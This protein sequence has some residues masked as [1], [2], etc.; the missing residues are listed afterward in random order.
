LAQEIPN[1]PELIERA[2]IFKLKPDAF[3][4][5]K[6]PVDL[7]FSTRNDLGIIIRYY[8]S[9]YSGL[10]ISN[11]TD[12]QHLKKYL[13]KTYYMPLLES[14]LRQR[15]GI[16]NSRLVIPVNYLY[17]ILTNIEYIYQ[18]KNNENRLY[19]KPL[20]RL[21]SPSLKFYLAAPLVLFALDRTGKVK[22]DYI[23]LFF[24]ELKFC[25]PIDINEDENIWEN[26]RNL[27]L[28]AYR[29]YNGF[30]LIK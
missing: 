30:H 22:D 11:W 13:I 12:L 15:S 5:E 26:A 20:A 7:W 3:I 8:L 19:F 4:V 17:H 18:L 27:Y 21:I 29:L 23:N 10:A 24:N 16:F 2:T 9:K 25:I 14:W 28:K 1:L 6:D